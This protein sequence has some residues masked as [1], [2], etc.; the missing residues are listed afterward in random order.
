[1][2]VHVVAGP[3]CAGK[4]TFCLERM[5]PR[6]DV[7]IDMDRLR[8]ALGAPGRSTWW[9]VQLWPAIDDAALRLRR[10]AL[11]WARESAHRSGTVWVIDTNGTH[12]PFHVRTDLNPGRAMCHERVALDGRPE[13][14][15]RIIDEWFD[16]FGDA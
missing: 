15:H 10:S 4:T 5:D 14:T 3:P 8:S 12:R 16:R 7:L 1:M 6:T 13:S 11:K 2:R 9:D